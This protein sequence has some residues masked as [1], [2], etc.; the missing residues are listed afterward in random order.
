MTT[1]APGEQF[2]ERGDRVVGR[3]SGVGEERGA[4]GL[5]QFAGGGGGLLGE[6]EGRAAVRRVQRVGARLDVQRV[7]QGLDQGQL[8][9]G[10][11]LSRSC[12]DRTSRF[13]PCDV[14]PHRAACGN[15]YRL[16]GSAGNDEEEVMP[17]A[18]VGSVVLDC[19]D[20]RA[21][22]DFYAG[23]VGGTVV[24]EGEWVDLRC[25][26]A[27]VVASRRPPVRTAA[28]AVGDGSQQFH[29]DL[30][31]EDLDAAEKE[32]LALGARPLD[33]DDRTRTFRVTRIRPGT[34][35]ACA[36]ADPADP[37]RMIH[38]PRAR[39]RSVVLDCPDPREL[40]VFYAAVGGGT[41]VEEDP[42]RVVLQVPAGSRLAFQRAPGHTPPKWPSADH[43][44]QQFHLDFDAGGTLGGS[45]RG[46]GE[47]AGTGGAGAGPGGLREQGLPGVRRSGGASVLPL[48]IEQ[49]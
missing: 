23:V 25:P 24:D 19:P 30:T 16:T 9:G 22:A 48:R 10:A 40:A 27:P 34:R 21:L 44:S 36:P 8:P 38:G 13:F 7:D 35:S 1:R 18:K 32:V 6:P 5:A 2:A 31:V 4:Q 37:R 15:G 46:R 43:D 47:G 26:A 49:P 12:L 42:D 17:V 33:A 11:A 3:V 41:P 45:R 14:T 28:V 29:L 39:F 20:P